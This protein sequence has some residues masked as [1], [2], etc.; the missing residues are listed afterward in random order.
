MGRI[1]SRGDVPSQLGVQ[2]SCRAV[3][4]QGKRRVLSENEL[5]ADAQTKHLKSN[6][7]RH[8]VLQKYILPRQAGLFT[9]IEFV[10]GP[11]REEDNLRTRELEI[12]RTLAILPDLVNLTSA[13]LDRCVADVHYNEDADP[14]YFEGRM[15]KLRLSCIALRKFS[16]EEAAAAAPLYANIPALELVELSS[17]SSTDSDD[18]RNALT[19]CT[20]LRQVSFDFLPP[21]KILPNQPAV[22]TVIDEW[23]LF[24]DWKSPLRRIAWSVDVFGA[25]DL[26]FLLAFSDSLRDLTILARD[27]KGIHSSLFISSNASN[28]SAPPPSAFPKLSTLTLQTINTRLVKVLDGITH[29][30]LTSLTLYRDN[31]TAPAIQHLVTFVQSHASTPRRLSFLAS[32]SPSARSRQ[33]LLDAACTQLGIELDRAARSGPSTLGPHFRDEDWAA[34]EQFEDDEEGEGTS[35]AYRRGIK[36]EVDRAL[37]FGREHAGR[38]EVQKD[39]V[40]MLQLL[41]QVAGLRLARQDHED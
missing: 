1:W 41:Q 32:G 35:E 23:S 17:V 37:E 12:C 13:T 20:H 31:T 16:H 4:L 21:P 40:G 33:Q 5:A 27:C 26:A 11:G 30:P 28:S 39:A 36:S 19:A 25:A 24:R 7:V 6:R 29:S 22:P 3:P 18:L 10:D 38:L 9:S 15:A 8:R 2:L 14:A 34:F